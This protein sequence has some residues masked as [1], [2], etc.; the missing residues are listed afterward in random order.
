MGDEID[1]L[2]KLNNIF[3]QRV[4]QHAIKNQNTTAVTDE[5]SLEKTHQELRV[6]E[7]QLPRVEDHQ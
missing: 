7:Y 4:Q 1:E 3:Q 2:R 6:T 5:K